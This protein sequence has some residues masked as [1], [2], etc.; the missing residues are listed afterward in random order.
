VVIGEELGFAG[1]VTLLILFAVIIL[2][3]V[4]LAA[5]TRHPFGSFLAIGAA[6]YFTFHVVV[7]VA[8]TTGLLPV[9]GLPLPLISYGGS[10]LLVSSF[11]I[12]LV[13]NV[14][15]RHYEE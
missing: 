8:I 13:L 15:T 6:A 3:S 11:L 5:L 10:N 1:A 9:T 7:N 4:N 14:S 12:G 2:R